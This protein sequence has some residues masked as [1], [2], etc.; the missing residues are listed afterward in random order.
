MRILPCIVKQLQLS[1]HKHVK[2]NR[3]KTRDVTNSICFKTETEENISP[4]KWNGCK[5]KI[6][7]MSGDSWRHEI[8]LCILKH[9]L[10]R[11]LHSEIF[12]IVLSN[13]HAKVNCHKS[14]DVINSMM[15]L[16]RKLRRI[17]VLHSETF[18]TF[19]S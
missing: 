13:R 5:F 9:S 18:I 11:I 16:K 10:R 17:S 8:P 14:R 19:P 1:N 6:I 4:A 15:F 2:V 7:D 12:I 3:H